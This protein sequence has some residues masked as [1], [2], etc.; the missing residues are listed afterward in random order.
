MPSRKFKKECPKGFTR[1]ELVDLAKDCSVKISRNYPKT[2]NKNM[3]ELCQE[4]SRKINFTI[5]KY[6]MNK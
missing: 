5:K 1:Q 6:K 4:I 3:K 2:G